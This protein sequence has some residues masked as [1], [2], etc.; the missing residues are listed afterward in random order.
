MIKSLFQT[1]RD[2]SSLL[3]RL[4]L[5]IVMFPHGAQHA[6]G[7]FGGYGFAGT[8]GWM[9]GTVGIPGFFAALA[10]VTEIVAPLAMA[11]GVLTRAAGFGIFMLLL[12]AA[13]THWENGFFMNWFGGMSAGVEGFEYHILGM[14]LAL[15]LIIKGA[16]RYSVDRLLVK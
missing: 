14:T 15:V 9:T 4:I 1:D 2:W 13:K 7:W 16:G 6:L 11:A 10:I 8:Y 5:G 12:V 3:V